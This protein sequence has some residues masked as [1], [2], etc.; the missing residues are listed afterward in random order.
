MLGAV[1]EPTKRKAR[2]FLLDDYS[3][4]TAIDRPPFQQYAEYPEKKHAIIRLPIPYKKHR[5]LIQHA[6]KT[7]RMYDSERFFAEFD[8]K[9]K[10]LVATPDAILGIH[11][12]ELQA[13][14]LRVTS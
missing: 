5:K 2:T 11:I 6:R 4:L 8:E 12:L 1:T 3:T 9:D 13:V 14:S 10:K 7:Q